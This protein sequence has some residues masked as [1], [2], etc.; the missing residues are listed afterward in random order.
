VKKFT[1][2]LANG[3]PEE[4]SVPLGT[5]REVLASVLPGLRK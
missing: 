4:G 1:S 3:D 5:A 2:M